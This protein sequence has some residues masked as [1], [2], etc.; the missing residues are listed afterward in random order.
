VRPLVLGLNTEHG[1][2]AA[3]LIG[4]EGPIA[5]IAEERLS[6]HKHTAEFPAHAIREVLRIA[7][8]SGRD[9]TAIAVARNPK[10]NVFGKGAFLLRN[11]PE[12]GDLVRRRLQTHK[13]VRSIHQSVGD[14]LGESVAHARLFQVEHHL[15]HAASAFYWSPFRRAAAL[16]IDGA[17]DFATAMWALGDGCGISVKR[18][19][20]W[21]HSLGVFY[22]A[23]CQLIGFDRY[24]EEFKVMGLSAYGRPAYLSALRQVV[25]FTPSQGLRLDLGYFRHHRGHQLETLVDGTVHFERL[26]SDKLVELLGPPRRRSEPLDERHRDIAASLQARYEEVFLKMVSH[27]VEITG[28]RDMV[29]AGGCLLN[30]VANGRMLTEGYIDRAYFQPAAT[31]DGTAVGAAHHVL[32]TRLGVRRCGEVKSA[33]WGPSWSDAEIEPY[34]CALG[35]PFVKLT[36]NEL[37]ERAAQAMLKGKIVGWFQGREEWGPRALGNRSILCNPAWPGMKAILNARIKNREPFRP[38]APVVRLA[39]LP[40]V[41]EGVHEV[42]FMVVVYKVREEWRARLPAVT[43]E[44]NTGRVQTVTREQNELYHDLIGRFAEL[45]GIP[46]LLNTSFNENEP[47]VH[48]PS[49][50]LACFER[51]QMDALAIGSYWLEKEPLTASE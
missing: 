51:T 15:A 38:F 17:G 16:T 32:H 10:A 40:V 11:L 46:V 42:P 35:R 30:S 36:N 27:A 48:S 39:D 45:P 21:P 50:A 20:L 6:R 13:R 44:D 9:V 41:F 8:A 31:D 37:L 18:R 1:D 24:G 28:C 14:A 43:H 25:D 7:G 33:F 4:A 22:T 12:A 29:F 26:Y 2:S 23:L 47:V 19:S 3:A 34:V 5:A 49:Q